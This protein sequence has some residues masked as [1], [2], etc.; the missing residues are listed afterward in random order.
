M[1][2]GDARAMDKV[3]PTYWATMEEWKEKEA[4]AL[5]LGLVPTAWMGPSGSHPEPST[6][7]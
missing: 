5:F 2:A 1:L 6:A 4:A 7:A 3:D